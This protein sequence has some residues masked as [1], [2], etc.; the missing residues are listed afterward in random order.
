MKAKL[1][2][3]GSRSA[4]HVLI[5]KTGRGI[6]QAYTW[7]RHLLVTR[8]GF[9]LSHFFSHGGIHVIAAIIVG[10]TALKLYHLTTLKTNPVY[11]ELVIKVSENHGAALTRFY[12]E[13]G[14]GGLL[15]K[16]TG[17]SEGLSVWAAFEKFD[18][19][20]PVYG[21]D[22]VIEYY[23]TAKN[24]YL[25]PKQFPGISNEIYNREATLEIKS[26]GSRLVVH[27]G[28]EMKPR[29]EKSIKYIP[30]CS[31]SLLDSLSVGYVRTKTYMNN[32]SL[33]KYR[34][35]ICESIGGEILSSNDDPDNPYLCF[36]MRICADL[37]KLPL[38]NG[39]DLIKIRFV[40]AI[41]DSSNGQSVPMN[42]INIFPKPSRATPG[43]IEY[44]G[45]DKL[46]EIDDN[47]GLYFLI[48]DLNKKAKS[49][50]KVYLYTILLGAAVAF[51]LDILVNL[52][53]KWR[54]LSEKEG[55]HNVR[56]KKGKRQK[57]ASNSYGEGKLPE[58]DSI[59][60]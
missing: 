9:E 19:L 49:D 47:G 2:I 46:I 35:F 3:S 59:E 55:Q 41:P 32:N 17:S 26:P 33:D 6:S 8:W 14:R 18:S 12:V 30:D 48:E 10:L 28:Y 4:P 60:E 39:G 54:N 50:R 21:K 5:R 51:F 34:I 22:S 31:A 44:E 20:Q 1:S 23:I 24:Q 56:T 11:K 27:E 7:S 15:K 43:N 52:V 38:M 57:I 37:N 58:Y 53:I 36:C 13:I 16:N 40:F 45:K 29:E 42:I 25:Y